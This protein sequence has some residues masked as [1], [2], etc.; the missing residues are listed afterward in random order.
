MVTLT[1]INNS[2]E[3]INNINTGC[4]DNGGCNCNINNNNCN[5]NC[6]DG[7][8]DINKYQQW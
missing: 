5:N 4:H 7:S 8:I 2:N 1:L 3:C 6:G